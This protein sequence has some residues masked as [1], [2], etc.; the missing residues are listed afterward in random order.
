M[1]S[2]GIDFINRE[3]KQN[4][5]TSFIIVNNLPDQFVNLL[6]AKCKRNYPTVKDVLENYS[7]ILKKMFRTSSRLFSNGPEELKVKTK[8][9]NNDNGSKS[10]NDSTAD[11]PENKNVNE[12]KS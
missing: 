9:R 1:L 4:V 12:I 5:L 10:N 11:R 8:P 3:L 6:I 7:D 2:F